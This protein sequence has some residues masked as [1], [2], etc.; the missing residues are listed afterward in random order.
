[1][2]QFLELY[3]NRLVN[4]DE[5][6]QNYLNSGNLIHDFSLGALFAYHKLE[7]L[8]ENEKCF[9][10]KNMILIEGKDKIEIIDY[11]T[12]KDA[13]LDDF[14]D[15]ELLKPCRT[16]LHSSKL[17]PHIKHKA[18]TEEVVYDLVTSQERQG[19]DHKSFY[20]AV[21]RPKSIIQR[22]DLGI[23]IEELTPD[24]ETWIELHKEWVNYKL[25][26]PGTFRI[27][28][29]TARYKRC[30][31]LDLIPTYKK[32]IF[33]KGQ[34][35]GFIVFSLEGKNAFELAFVSLYF[36]P[37]FKIISGLN[38]YLFSYFLQ[39]LQ[40]LGIE[41]VNSGFVL[42]KKLAVFKKTSQRSKPIIRYTYEL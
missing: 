28:F 4:F 34:P 27:A 14:F 1:M 21:N 25:A 16:L 2:K 15:F 33:I 35:Y 30:L 29:P 22:K 10:F 17:L 40:K 5:F 18:K 19:R 13:Y 38:Q 11:D 20:H 39:E 24:S 3:N 6:Q 41:K 23:E 9:L 8:I 31:N 12:Q 32:A 36:K 7:Q 37:E 42:N 26:Q